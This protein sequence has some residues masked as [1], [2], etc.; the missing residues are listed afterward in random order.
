MRSKRSWLVAL[1]CVLMLAAGACT[2]DPEE[3][4]DGGSDGG[5]STSA[6]DLEPSGLL[7]D[8]GPC[9]PEL[10]VYPLGQMTVFESAVLSLIDQVDGA[11]AAIEAFNERG[12]VGGH[13]ME[14]N[15]C[16]TQLD[17][18]GEVDCARKLVD[19]GVVATINDTTA[20]NPD[21]IVE[22]TGE[23]GLPRIGVSPAAQE[24]ASPVAFPLSGGSSGTTFMMFSA[25]ARQDIT[26]IAMIHVDTPQ[27][28]ALPGFAA[29][30]LEAYGAEIT[31]M[32]PVPAGT[33][34]YQQFVLA[35][36]DSGAEGV[37][38]A[39]GETEALQVVRAAEQVGTDLTFSL[40]LGTFG[41]ADLEGFGDFATN[42]VFNSEVPPATGS[43]DRWPALADVLIDLGASDEPALQPDELKSSPIRSWLAVYALVTVVEEFGDPDDVSREAIQTAFEAAKDVDMLDLVAPWTPRGG[44]GEGLFGPVSNPYYY[45]VTFD[46]EAKDYVIGDDQLNLVEEIDGNLDYPQPGE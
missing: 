17:P 4:S 27:V 22:V 34:D 44:S 43:L 7:A 28:Q 25:L 3:G 24:L 23:A 11:K 21:G 8:D 18:N 42:M 26:K 9:D 41:Q 38:M 5:Q 1:V 12:G 30:M 10:E 40:S 45:V 14:L 19:D 37:V 35:A 33:T 6:E 16:D 15:A 2:D 46:P 29:P 31:E 39:L 32:I 36:E 13:C 20:A